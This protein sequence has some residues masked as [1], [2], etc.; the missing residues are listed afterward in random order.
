VKQTIAEELE[1]LGGGGRFPLAAELFQRM[2]T[3]PECP[4]FLTKVAYDYLD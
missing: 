3:Q 4:E 2:T 1:R